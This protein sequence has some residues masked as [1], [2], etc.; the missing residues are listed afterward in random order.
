LGIPKTGPVDRLNWAADGHYLVTHN[1]N[2]TV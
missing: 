1:G 2:K